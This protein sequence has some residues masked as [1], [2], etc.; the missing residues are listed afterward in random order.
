MLLLAL[1]RA[2]GASG[3]LCYWKKGEGG[4]GGGGHKLLSFTSWW[5]NRGINVGFGRAMD[6]TTTT[7]A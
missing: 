7:N 3:F 4:G 1:A 6:G 2:R 5:W